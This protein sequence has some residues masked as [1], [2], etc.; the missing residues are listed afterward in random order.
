MMAQG[1]RT[2]RTLDPTCRLPR[3]PVRPRGV[4]GKS[5]RALSESSPCRLDPLEYWSLQ[6]SVRESRGSESVLG[7]F[8]SGL[9]LQSSF[10]F[11]SDGAI[12]CQPL[13]RQEIARKSFGSSASGQKPMASGFGA[14]RSRR[15]RGRGAERRGL[16]APALSLGQDA[17]AGWDCAEKS[18]RASKKSAVQSALPAGAFGGVCR[19]EW[20]CPGYICSGPSLQSSFHFVLGAHWGV[21]RFGA[22]KSQSSNSAVIRHALMRLCSARRRSRFLSISPDFMSSSLLS[23]H[24]LSPLPAFL[25]L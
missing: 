13:R 19:G 7:T 16:K 11:S 17:A 20:V 24:F 6:R 15:R 22:Q 1:V 21:S 14:E 3:R 25:R 10:H 5:G 2:H 9:S 8:C 23:R 4:C 12:V 18:G